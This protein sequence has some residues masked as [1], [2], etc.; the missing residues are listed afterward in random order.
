[1]EIQKITET[2]S[3]I[4]VQKI[5][6][7]HSRDTRLKL[8]QTLEDALSNK[9][10]KLSD[11]SFIKIFCTSNLLKEITQMDVIFESKNKEIET[12]NFKACIEKYKDESN[13]DLHFILPVSFND[14][15]Q[16]KELLETLKS[17]IDTHRLIINILSTPHPT[18]AK[19]PYDPYKDPNF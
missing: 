17:K 11:C 9:P 16:C 18:K 6:I 10:I 7:I 4:E 12:T 8:I 15:E 2:K 3:D 14:A 5:S 1:M 19:E 13:E